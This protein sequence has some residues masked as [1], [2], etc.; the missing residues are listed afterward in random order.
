VGYGAGFGP[1]YGAGRGTGYGAGRVGYGAGTGTGYGAG[2][3]ASGGAAAFSP[4]DVAG[5]ALW[6]DASDIT[7]LWQDSGRTTPVT[8]DTDPVGAIDDKSGNA[9]HATQAVAGSR[10]TYRTAQFGAVAA[11]DFDGIADF[12]TSTAFTLTQPG[13]VFVVVDADVNVSF[14]SVVDSATAGSRWD[15]GHENSVT[16]KWFMFAGSVATAGEYDQN[17]H[18]LVALFNGA[19]SN[20]RVD[21]GAGTVLNPGAQSTNTPRIGADDGSTSFFDGRVGEVLFYDSS[22]SVANINAVGEYLAT[23]W[24][25]TW[26]AAS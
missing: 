13:V 2:P 19:S 15:V 6:L 14:N 3:G 8:A 12:L 9:R 20:L 23:K 18:V 16:P 26:S 25:I 1:G 17:P 10:P 4:S 21:G 24:G 7:T 22:L 11:M 5:L